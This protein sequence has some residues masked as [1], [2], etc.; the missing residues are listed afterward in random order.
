MALALSMLGSSQLLKLAMPWMAANAI[1]TLQLG[2]AAAL[3][4]SG[5]WIAA[6]LAMQVGIWILHG[7]ARVMERTVALRVRRSVA[8]ALY[9]RLVHAPLNWHDRHHSADLQHRVDQASGALFGFTQ[10]QF[11]YLQNLINLVGPL[12]AFRHRADASGNPG[13]SR[14][15]QICRTAARLHRQHLGGR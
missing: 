5:A 12:V 14:G 6:I 2:G 1:N 9:A 11:M 4:T 10:N 7:P 3:P 15:T 13:E 8:D